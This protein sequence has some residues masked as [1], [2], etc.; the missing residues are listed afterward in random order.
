MAR[1]DQKYCFCPRVQVSP[2][3]TE[4]VYYEHCLTLFLCPLLGHIFEELTIL[5]HAKVT[6]EKSIPHSA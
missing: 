4:C 6:L 3:M 1:F 2:M 5:R